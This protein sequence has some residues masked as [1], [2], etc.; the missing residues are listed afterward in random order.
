MVDTPP[1]PTSTRRSG[2]LIGYRVIELGG[3]GPGPFAGCVLADL[4]ADVVEVERPGAA[5][6]LR[7]ANDNLKLWDRGKRSIAVDLSTCEGH[8]VLLDLAGRPDALIDPFR[9]GV[10]ERLGVGPKEVLSRNPHLVYGRITGWGQ[11]GPLRDRAGHDVNYLAQA[12]ALFH[13]GRTD[14]K[15]AFPLNV[16]GDFG[17]GGMLLVVGLI[18]GLLHSTRTGVGQ[19]VDAAMIDGVAT[20]MMMFHALAA[21]GDFDQEHRGGNVLDSGAHFYEVYECAD[22]EF[23]AVGAVSPQFYR[24]LLSKLGFDGKGLPAQFDR[25]GW[26]E[27]KDRFAAVFRT[28]TRDEWCASLDGQD[29]CVS[30]VLRIRE[31]VT[32]AHHRARGTFVELDGVAQ[33]APAPRFS[34]TPG[35]VHRPP[36]SP[37][38][39][40]RDVL[41]DWLELDHTEIDALSAAGAVLGLGAA[42]DQPTSTTD[43]TD[44]GIAHAR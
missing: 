2:P 26:S 36:P 14:S 12:G 1:E 8:R 39:N 27:M 35:H 4:G 44:S 13:F 15:P 21:M 3:I 28:K 18:A 32:D 42:S 40:G 17:G 31:A 29:V 16:V 11:E 22:G 34:H 20:Q 38:F 30:P 43:R 5:K 10:A 9:P 41:A 23:L 37:G 6:L 7:S 24:T 33:P 19:V 25:R